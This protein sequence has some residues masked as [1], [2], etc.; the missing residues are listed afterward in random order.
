MFWNL[1]DLEKNFSINY[2]FFAIIFYKILIALK[3]I[4]YLNVLGRVLNALK[5][6]KMKKNLILLLLVF[7][8]FAL[9][10]QDLNDEEDELNLFTHSVASHSAPLTGGGY[11]FKK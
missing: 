9:N 7:I 11:G 10:S 8:P 5:R 2:L 6:I 4:C 1:L 3:F